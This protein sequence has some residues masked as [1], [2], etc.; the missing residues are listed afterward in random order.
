MLVFELDP[1]FWDAL[2]LSRQRPHEGSDGPEVGGQQ[3]MV[4][5]RSGEPA[6]CCAR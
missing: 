1:S 4:I 5:K 6:E 3:A 2:P